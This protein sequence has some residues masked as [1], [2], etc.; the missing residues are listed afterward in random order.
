MPKPLAVQLYT[1]RDPERFGGAGLGL[2]PATLEALAAI[3]YLGVETVDVPGGDAVLARRT[4]GDLGLAVTSAHTWA[5]IDDL[6]AF[7]RAASAVADL[8]ARTIIKSGSGFEAVWRVEAFANR[9]NDAARIAARYGLRLAYH[10]HDV[11]MRP[12]DGVA[13]YRRMLERLDPAVVFQVDIF[14]VAVGGAVPAEVIEE[15]GPRVISLHLK[16]GSTLPSTAAGGETFVNVP[17]GDGVVEVGAAVA[18]AETQPSVEWLIV[19]FDHVDG[20]PI[21]AVRR[22]YDN[23][24]SRGLGRG[25]GL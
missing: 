10:N 23:L 22:S 18:A 15:L 21:D 16:D 24:T 7:D 11:E 6:E 13:V 12:L 5:S 19:E 3:G 25:R 4:L 9:L 17:V 20:S 14:W 2:D 8:G 1:F